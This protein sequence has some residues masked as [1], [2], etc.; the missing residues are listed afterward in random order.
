VRI[1]SPSLSE[2]LAAV[3]SFVSSSSAHQIITANALMLLA[4]RDDAA[5]AAAFREAS[6]VVPDSAGVALAA[7]L[8]GQRIAQVLPGVELVDHICRLAAARGWRVFLL[9][10]APGV[11]EAA[12]RALS[13]RH[14]G[15]AVAGTRHGYFPPDEEPNVL[16]EVSAARADVL[17]AALSVPRQDVWVHRNLGRLG[18]KAAMGVGGSFDVLSGRLRRAPRW[19][20][21]AGLEWLFRL[22]QEPWRAGRMARLPV[23][24][25]KAVWHRLAG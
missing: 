25:A 8:T 22:A 23:F 6:L 19:M 24:F 21:R 9:G 20:S 14:P 12:A 17:F 1:D 11:A 18:C 3:E 2:A 5:L 13:E 7:R 4:V 10:A 16:R 15:L